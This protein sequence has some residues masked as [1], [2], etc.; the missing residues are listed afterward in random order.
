MAENTEPYGKIL[1]V[2][3]VHGL[4][5]Q[6]FN[7]ISFLIYEQKEN[8]D[9]VVSLGDFWKGRNFN[10]EDI[11][12][13]HWNDREVFS[14]LNLNIFHI[15]GNEDQDIPD[16]FWTTTKNIW[17]MPNEKPFKANGLT[18]FPVYF[19]HYDEKHDIA[20]DVHQYI[21]S[22][23]ILATHNPAFGIL[24][25][26]L[27]YKTHEV[28]KSTGSMKIRKYLDELNP[29]LHIF[30]HFHYSNFLKYKNTLVVCLDKMYRINKAM[31]KKFSYALVDP[32]ERTV[33][34]WWRNRHY[35]KYNML[36]REI[37]FVDDQRNTYNMVES[38]YF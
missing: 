9:F 19:T 2:S 4:I 12:R 37:K 36:E 22:I 15:K 34:V 27:H 14:S 28:I 30:G 38:E 10:G 16:N 31:Q 25:N 32:F 33:D 13:D 8:I 35:I 1:F 26:T 5:P 21:N 6:L 17:L 29:A 23:D 20:K 7:L 3:D 11:V 24:D 18:L